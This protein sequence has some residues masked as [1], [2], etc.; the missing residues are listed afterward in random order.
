MS[1]FERA[2]MAGSI[3][4]LARKEPH[5]PLEQRISGFEKGCM[6]RVQNSAEELQQFVM[7]SFIDYV[8]AADLLFADPYELFD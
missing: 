3:L 4:G 2:V 6:Q 5:T 7:Q 8:Q 1:E